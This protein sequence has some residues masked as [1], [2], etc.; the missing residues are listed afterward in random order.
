MGFQLLE[1]PVHF[2]LCFVDLRPELSGLMAPDFPASF[3]LDFHG[4]LLAPKEKP[5]LP[6]FRI[7]FLM[8]GNPVANGISCS[9]WFLVPIYFACDASSIGP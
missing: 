3:D 6:E 1:S 5:T 7:G 9:L 2:G 4:V 8:F